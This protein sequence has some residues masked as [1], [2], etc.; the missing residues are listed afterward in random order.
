MPSTAPASGLAWSNG[1]LLLRSPGSVRPPPHPCVRAGLVSRQAAEPCHG[2]GGS[3]PTK[4]C[5]CGVQKS[6]VL[7]GYTFACWVYLNLIKK[8][9]YFY[10]Y[11][12][13]VC[14]SVCTMSVLYLWRWE[15][16]VGSPELE[17]QAVVSPCWCWERTLVLLRGSS[18]SSPG[19]ALFV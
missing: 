7:F 16:G 17:S 15:G 8:I 4:P 6:W 12:H 10:V 14:T 19:L 13:F 18:C 1:W 11:G 3:G 5:F 2:E 9:F